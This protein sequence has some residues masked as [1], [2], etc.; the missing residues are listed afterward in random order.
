MNASIR[1]TPRRSRASLPMSP[2][3]CHVAILVAL[4]FGCAPTKVDAPVTPASVEAVQRE[5]QGATLVVERLA[6][7]AGYSMEGSKGGRF[8][9]NDTAT[10]ETI[11][12]ESGG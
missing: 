9:F 10:T 12:T 3:A 1:K 5:N 7:P 4:T 8:F 11:V 2:P 6:P